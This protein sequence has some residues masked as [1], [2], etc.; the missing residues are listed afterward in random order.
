LSENVPSPPTSNSRPRLALIACRVLEAEIAALA[1]GEGAGFVRQEFFEI[2]LHDQPTVLRARLAE[3]IERAEADPGVDA[4]VLV[5][6]LCGMAL[7]ELGPRRCPLVVP[8]AH[9]CLTL[10][11]G[12]KERYAACMRAEPGTYWYTPGWCRGGRVPGPEREAQLRS[13]YMAKYDAETAEALLEME[14]EAF[15]QHACAG[16]V[17][18]GLPGDAEH[19]RY[20]EACAGTQ[21]WRF[22]AHRGDPQLLREL[23][24]GAWDAGRFLVV[25]PGERI[26][27]D[28][29]QIMKAVRAEAG[30]GS[31]P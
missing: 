31:R 15:G 21:G 3:A 17:D 18:F 12:S 25:Q 14:R 24:Q 5:Y 28:T 6:G 2:G 26:A 29:D 13:E 10:F 4:V 20:A 16:Y 7:V 9:D 11:L 8:R 22:E 23:L 30:V 19:R 1:D 27:Y